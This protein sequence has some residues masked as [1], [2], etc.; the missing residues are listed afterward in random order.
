MSQQ[1]SRGVALMTVIATCVMLVALALA[2]GL[3]GDSGA[4]LGQAAPLAVVCGV[5]LTVL[6]V[7]PFA[8][9]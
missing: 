6:L 5:A 7:D 9:R 2:S 3:N 1:V 8:S 4:A